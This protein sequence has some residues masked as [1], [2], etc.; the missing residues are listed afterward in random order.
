MR[1]KRNEL[2]LKSVR[3]RHDIIFDFLYLYNYFFNSIYID[4][5][6][7]YKYVKPRHRRLLHFLILSFTK[8]KFFVNLKNYAKKNYLFLSPGFFIKFFEKKKSFKKNKI[9]KLLMSKYVRKLFLISNIQNTVL[10]IKRNPINLLEIVNLFNTP[11]VHKFLNPVDR[12]IKEEKNLN[13]T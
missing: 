9:I 6:Y 5:F 10:I 3:L 12:K 2:F 7:I 4:I 8:N 1:I 11:I 13:F